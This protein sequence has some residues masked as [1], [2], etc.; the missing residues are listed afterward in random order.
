MAIDMNSLPDQVYQS[1][2]IALEYDKALL[3]SSKHAFSRSDLNPSSNIE[4]DLRISAIRDAALS[5]G[6][7]AGLYWKAEQINELI[8]Q[9]YQTSLDVISF[10]PL[11]QG[12]NLLMPS[13]GITHFSEVIRDGVLYNVRESYSIDAPSKLVTT[14]PTYRDYLT[15]FF[16]QPSQV[17]SVLKPTSKRERAVWTEYVNQGWTL[18]VGQAEAIFQDGLNRFVKD[19]LGRINYR[20]SLSLGRVSPPVLGRQNYIQ[21]F[22]GDTTYIGE[23]RFQVVEPA[24][25]TSVQEQDLPFDEPFPFKEQPK[26]SIGVDISSNGAE[27]VELNHGAPALGEA[28][29]SKPT[30][31]IKPARL[32]SG[33]MVQLGSFR[34][35]ANA[36]AL[37]D[38]VIREGFD[39]N[40]TNQ[41]HLFIVM[42]GPEA[43]KSNANVL[44][45]KLGTQFGEDSITIFYNQNTDGKEE[46][47]Q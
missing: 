40:V 44:Q 8:T 12:T 15:L 17:H 19:I 39:A 22:D 18:G 33:W 21:T 38:K 34:I 6:T 2:H 29:T 28:A 16:E 43:T 7:K 35:E 9:K 25:L 4:S 31:K 32:L 13:V 27:V 26:T 46:S 45:K 30:G 3:I 47:Q 14:A 41:S 1:E 11:M 37:K 36:I 10:R 42:A 20:Q 5:Y 23:V 24:S